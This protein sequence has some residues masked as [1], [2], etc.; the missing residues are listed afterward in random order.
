M[1]FSR[2]Q[3]SDHRERRRIFVVYGRKTSHS[4]SVVLIPPSHVRVVRATTLVRMKVRMKG[5]IIIAWP[6]HFAAYKG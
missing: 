1:Q 5:T 2:V 6:S 3:T 4:V